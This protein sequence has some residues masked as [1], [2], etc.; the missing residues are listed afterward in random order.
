MAC[1]CL[2]S[3]LCSL[4]SRTFAVPRFCVSANLS[5]PGH[6]YYSTSL[7]AGVPVYPHFG[8]GYEMVIWL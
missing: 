4:Y 6:A 7:E 8:E 3:A 2:R 5:C 1:S